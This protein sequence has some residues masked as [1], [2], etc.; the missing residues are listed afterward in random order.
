MPLGALANIRYEIEQPAIRRRS[1]L[2][3]ITLQWGIRDGVQPNTVVERLA[4]RVADLRKEAATGRLLVSEVRSGERQE[5]RS[6]QGCP[7]AHAF[8]MATILMIQLQSFSRLSWCAR[9]RRSR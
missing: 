7:S 3:T 6:N 5:P 8:V 2:T 9:S 4:P 1:R